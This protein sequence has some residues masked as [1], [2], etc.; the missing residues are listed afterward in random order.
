MWKLFATV[1]AMSDTGSIAVSSLATDFA[2]RNACLTAARELFP[3]K[4]ENSLQG[5]TVTI[6]TT[7]ECRPDGGPLPPPPQARLPIVPPFF[8][9]R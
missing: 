5:R 6:R 2:D 4:T 8:L 1:L 3:A 7:A 9:N